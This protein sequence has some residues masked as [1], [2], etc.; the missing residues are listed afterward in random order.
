MMINKEVSRERL[1]RRKFLLENPQVEKKVT[2]RWKKE[3]LKRPNREMLSYYPLVDI[4]Q[5]NE[6]ILQNMPARS[7]DYIRKLRQCALN[8]LRKPF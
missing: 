4:R 2:T 5:Q 3:E 8:K 7:E 6:E 1:L